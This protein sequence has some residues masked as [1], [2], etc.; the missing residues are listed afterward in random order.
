MKNTNT[1][2]KKTFLEGR[3]AGKRPSLLSELTETL[4]FCVLADLQPPD[5]NSITLTHHYYEFDL[6]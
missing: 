1:F 6:L 2:Y 5:D 3:R 4:L